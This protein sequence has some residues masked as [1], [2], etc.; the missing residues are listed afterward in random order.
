MKIVSKSLTET[1]EVAEKFLEHVKTVAS[2]DGATVVAMD[3]DLGSGKTALTKLIAEILEI[4]ETITSPTFVIQKS[5]EINNQNVPWK[6]LIHIDAYRLNGGEELL[7]LGFE[8][9]LENAKN[10]ILVEWPEL[11]KSALPDKKVEIFCEFVDEDTRV[12]KW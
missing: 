6:K 3:G 12:Y 8:E 5:Y 9:E 1:K 2:N 4:D 7:K 10:L 11:V